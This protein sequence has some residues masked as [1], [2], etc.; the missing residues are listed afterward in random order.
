KLIFLPLSMTA[1]YNRIS[2][3]SEE[4]QNAVMDT[5][6]SEHTAYG[7][8]ES[9]RNGS[10]VSHQSLSDYFPQDFPVRML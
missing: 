2:A 7:G 4:K 1:R 6:V 9:I 8:L 3:D 10:A 5:G